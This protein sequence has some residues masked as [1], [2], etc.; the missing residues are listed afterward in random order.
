MTFTTSA[1]A[2]TA[3]TQAATSITSSSAQ[4]NSY[5]NPNGSSTTI[6]FQYGLTTS[7]GS[8]TISGNI[9]TTA[10]NYGTTV[11]GLTPNTTYH[12]RIVASNS[13]GYTYGSDMT[14]A[15]SGQPPT[16]QTQ[17]ATLI[18]ANSAQLNSY[19]DPNGFSTTIYFQYG[20]TASYGS[21]TISGNIATAAGNYG[22]QASALSPN[23]TYHFRIVAYN[24]NGTNYGN[25][26]TLTT[27]TQGP[28]VQTLAATTVTTTS[29]QLNGSLNPNGLATTAYFQYGT[30]ASYGS[31]T[32]SGSF[33]ITAQNIGYNVT[34]LAANT[35]YHFRIVASN[36]SGTSTGNDMTFT[37]AGSG[38]PIVQTLAAAAV[39]TTSA[40]LNGSINPNGFDTTAFFEY[41]LTTS[42]G[43][44]TASGDFGTTSQNIGFVHTGLSPN[45]TYHY[46]VTASNSQG[47][48][49]GADASFTTLPTTTSATTAWV[50]GTSG[51]GLCLRSAPSLS[52][53]V[54]LVMPE[55]SSVTLLGDTQTADGYLWRHL[56]YASQ[57]GW[58]AAQYLVFN[59]P[60]SAPAAPITLRQL[61]PDGFSPVPA[62]GSL[63]ASSAILAA[64]PSGPSSQQYSIQI[65]VRPAA[66]SFSAPTATSDPVQ[67]GSEA[68][69]TLS[70]L[71][72]QG[73]HWRAR[74][75]DAYGQVSGWVQYGDGSAPDFTVGAASLVSALFGWTPAVPL[76]GN[77]IQ[78]TAQAT[79]ATGW[80]F[81]WSFT[82]GQT[83]TGT[84][85]SQTFA[86]AGPV[87]ATLT[88]TDPQ[89]HQ[90]T[91]TEVVQVASS[92]LVDAIN[93]LAQQTS[94]LLDQ[95]SSQAQLAAGA[96]DYFQSAV[97]EAPSDIAISAAFTTLSLGFAGATDYKQWIKTTT[98]QDAIG[99]VVNDLE[100]WAAGWV[101]DQIFTSGQSHSAIFMPNIQAYIAQK[102]T[103]IE[104]QRQAAIAAA[105]SFTSQQAAQMAQNLQARYVGNLAVSDDYANKEALPVTFQA[106][107]TADESSW[108][109]VAGEHIFDVSVGIGLVALAP[110]VGASGALATMLSVST[111]AG[112]GTL[113]IVNILSQQSTDAQMLGL[114]LG[115]LGQA[116]ISAKV[117]TDNAE[118]GLQDVVSSQFPT[119]PAG[120]MSVQHVYIRA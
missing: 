77:P 104:Q 101:R 42:Y 15:T 21:T 4:L 91:Q 79:A 27:T 107:K 25:D 116:T 12:F 64:T 35:T 45:T 3:T 10:G 89:G 20:L 84:T 60:Q 76:S 40:Q 92:Q 88:V 17:A 2:P 23:T 11:S 103:E 72:N 95:I 100:Q 108:T 54:I 59:P 39:T 120:Q 61:Q 81:Q 74:T 37:T 58:A 32:P 34:G 56:T 87:T 118:N 93:K 22:T 29:A 94:T 24:S 117:M 46:R 111:T 49:H 102:K 31:T 85:V 57:T 98:G 8:N 43:S 18:T 71:L 70:G 1:Q 106:I 69:I 119:T 96:A 33:G 50:A 41:G 48:T 19:V 44:S 114:S 65:E 110:E 5:V 82:G 78:F 36:N 26:L 7:Y 55:G 6:Y 86:Q 30:T 16:A 66:T 109:L 80:T 113:D 75:M 47:T 99:V 53:S 67:G 97:D 63:N 9:G 51:L 52:S 13:G 14:F 68:R 112:L 73:Y 62:G 38:A 83:P 105:G 28:T 90:A 115:V